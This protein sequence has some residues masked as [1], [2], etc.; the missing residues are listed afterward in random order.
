MVRN[1]ENIIKHE[2]IGI[3]TEVVES[4]NPINIGIS[5]EI[6][7]ETKKTIVIDD[8]GKLK[9]VFKNQV[10]LALSLPKQTVE[11]N[12]SLLEGRPWDRLKKR[13]N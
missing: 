9:R 4:S 3:H 5:G 11:V 1:A 10:S 13:V 12:G 8:K 7:N 2:I 6:V